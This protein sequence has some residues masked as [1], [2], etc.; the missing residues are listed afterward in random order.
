VGE[1]YRRYR[2]P[3]DVPNWGGEN[4]L[5]VRAYADGGAGGIWSVRRERPPRAW[6]AEGAPRWWTVLLVN[7][8]DDAQ[9]IAL[10]LTA[11][12]IP[13]ASFAAYDVWRDAPLAEPRGALSATLAPHSALTV[14]L[15]A[16][17]PHPQV[18]G[19]SRHV[20]QGSVDLVDEAWDGTSRTLRAK[21]VNLDARAYAVTVAVPKGM[22]VGACHAEPPCTVRSLPSGHAVLVWPAGGDGR[23]VAWELRFRPATARADRRP[24]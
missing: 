9:E 17:S 24:R 13:G 16:T 5:A 6:V 3:P 12:G 21:S 14:A 8:D 2:V 4:V 23:D 19:T 15:R 22:R 7:W 20:V 10:P 18:I 1:A 11:L